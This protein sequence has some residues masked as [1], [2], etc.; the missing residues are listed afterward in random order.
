MCKY[1]EKFVQNNSF[2]YLPSK[3]KVLLLDFFYFIFLQAMEDDISLDFETLSRE[4]V[5]EKLHQFGFNASAKCNTSNLR[6]KL[7]NLAKIHHPIH[8]FLNQMSHKEVR[9]V[10]TIIFSKNSIQNIE[11]IKVSISNEFFKKFPKS[12]LTA[13]KIC[14]QTGKFVEKENLEKD[15][16]KQK[17]EKSP[18]EKKR[19]LAEENLHSTKSRKRKVHGENTNIQKTSRA[20]GVE[21][22]D[23]GYYQEIVTPFIGRRFHNNRNDCY[24]N[25]VMNFI[26][27][28]EELRKGIIE[29]LC[30]CTLCNNLRIFLGDSRTVHL[31]DSVKNLGARL[32]PL[33]FGGTHL[34]KQ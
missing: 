4:E 14:V 16:Q 31:T 23:Y 19:K 20:A 8:E 6:T 3:L 17:V 15:Q 7:R 13:L 11:R 29:N 33:V 9:K 5:L 21:P 2:F 34:N 22:S 12:P 1:A 30:Q 27:S 25:S 32:N 24:V 10:Y 26:M 18:Q 28:S